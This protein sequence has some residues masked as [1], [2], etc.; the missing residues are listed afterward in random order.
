MALRLSDGDMAF[1]TW[2]PGVL[3]ATDLNTHI[4]DVFAGA[5]EWEA[6]S[7]IWDAATT[8]PA[9]GNGVL[10]GAYVA[11]GDVVDVGIYLS[12]GSTTAQGSGAWSFSL[13]PG[14]SVH[15]SFALN[16]AGSCSDGSLHTLTAFAS[17]G[18]TSMIALRP[19]TDA[20]VE[21]GSPWTFVAGDWLAL[22]ARFRKA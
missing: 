9:I 22:S 14:M 21:P 18:W 2:A 15:S 3:T 13:P 4:R 10:N 17:P 7:P 19:S 20:T 5:G 8:L 16:G 1:H 6:Y 12:L 11:L